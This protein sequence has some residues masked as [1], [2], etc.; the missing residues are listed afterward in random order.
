VLFALFVVHVVAEGRYTMA[1]VLPRS[2]STIHKWFDGW[3][4]CIL[5]NFFVC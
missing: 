4:F 3:A 2:I 1:E 5:E